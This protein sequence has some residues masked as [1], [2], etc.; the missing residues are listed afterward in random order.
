[1]NGQMGEKCLDKSAGCEFACYSNSMSNK[2]S[3]DIELEC[4]VGGIT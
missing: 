4:P 2:D 1:M 3:F